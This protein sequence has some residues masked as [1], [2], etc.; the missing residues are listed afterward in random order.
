MPRYRTEIVVAPDR[1]VSLRLPDGFP[2]GRAIVTVD[3]RPDEDPPP[4]LDH[5]PNATDPDREDIEW[6]EEFEDDVA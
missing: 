1:F 6:W 2:E 5:E 3:A 4:R